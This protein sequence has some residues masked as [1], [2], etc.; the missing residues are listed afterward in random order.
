MKCVADAVMK[1]VEEAIES[2]AE[3]KGVE[4]DEF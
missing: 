4:L 2:R 1:N 3:E